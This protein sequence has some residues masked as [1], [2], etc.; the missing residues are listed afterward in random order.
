MIMYISFYGFYFFLILVHNQKV[1]TFGFTK[2]YQFVTKAD[3]N[4]AFLGRKT[5]IPDQL[6]IMVPYISFYRF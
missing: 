6:H 4:T 1:L 5:H 3:R 2:K